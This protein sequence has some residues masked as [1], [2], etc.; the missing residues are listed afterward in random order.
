MDISNVIVL[1]L[2]ILILLGFAIFVVE[3]FIPLQMKLEVHKICK[4]YLFVLEREGSLDVEDINKINH[5]MVQ[6]GLTS[7]VIEVSQN[8]EKFGDWVTFKIQGLYIN[9]P[10]IELF[11][12]QSQVLEFN[13]EKEISIR[14]IIN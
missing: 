13:Y 6:I 11:K 1:A 4:P 3:L 5:H 12:R 7:V 14:K 2:A 9:E 8:G 10:M